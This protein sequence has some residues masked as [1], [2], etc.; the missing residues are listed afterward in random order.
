MVKV[1]VCDRYEVE[2]L[3]ILRAKG[4]EVDEKPQ[5]TTEELIACVGEYDAVMIR[6]RAK[7]TREV[8]QAGTKLKAVARA[9]VG[10]DN[11][12]VD[13]AKQRGIQVISTPEASTTSVAELTIGLMLGVLRQIGYADRNLKER[14]W[15]KSSITGR[16]LK[17][18][19]VGIIGA[20]GRIG[21]EVARLLRVGF[22]CHVIGYDVTDFSKQ[23]EKLGI[24]V[25]E[26][27]EE[28]LAK[29][30][31][32]TV[33][34]PYV[35]STHHLINENRLRLMKKNAILVNAA[36]GDIIDGRALLDA[37]R[38][39][40]IGGAALDVY[41]DEPPK[42]EWEWQLVSL[43]NTLCTCHIGAQTE[44]CQ[45]AGGCM[46]VEQLLEVLKT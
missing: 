40:Q 36:R 24:E 41:H 20:G 16:E 23:A 11:V 13:Y 12:D 9:G 26:T 4:F 5:I 42:E 35:P 6:S 43:P 19:A 21:N 25:A 22:G 1:L 27:V 3:R 32:V 37:L 18:K 2:V 46:V 38:N 28:L 39:G 30:D 33:H 31:I 29:A 17:N 15:A 14:K 44:E 7:V 10:L 34:V 8:L 45:I